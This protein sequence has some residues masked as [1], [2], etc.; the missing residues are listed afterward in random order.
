VA[1]KGVTV[2]VVAPGL[3]ETAMTEGLPAAAREE[4]LARTPVGRAVTSDEVAAAVAF[5]ASPTAG[6]ITG[7]VLP[8]DGGASI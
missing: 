3:V 8:V 6:A 4:L 1:R 2:N 7:A 5:L